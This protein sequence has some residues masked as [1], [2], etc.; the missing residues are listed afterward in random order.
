MGQSRRHNGF[1]KRL[2]SSSMSASARMYLDSSRRSRRVSRRDRQGR[3]VVSVEG[4]RVVLQMG[5]HAVDSSDRAGCRVVR[6]E[7]GHWE[8]GAKEENRS[9]RS[10]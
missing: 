9:W 10:K 8:A 6:R 4:L 5:A 2:S 3:P 7:K 1:R